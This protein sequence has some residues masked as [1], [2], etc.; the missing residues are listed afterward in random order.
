MLPIHS[1][2]T[3]P[4]PRLLKATTALLARLW[5]APAAPNRNMWLSVF[6]KVI[7]P[8]QIHRRAEVIRTV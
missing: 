6:C 1:G 5:P 2:R 4:V 3:T 8:F 7:R